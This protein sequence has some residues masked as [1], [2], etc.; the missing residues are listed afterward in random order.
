M[1]T[2]VIRDLTNTRWQLNEV[3]SG[4]TNLP[5]EYP[6]F[7]GH[8]CELNANIDGIK[9][10]G[11]A[12]AKNIDKRF[13]SDAGGILASAKTDSGILMLTL[14]NNLARFEDMDLFKSNCEAVG[15]HNLS[16]GVFERSVYL[17]ISLTTSNGNTETYTP[18]WASNITRRILTIYSGGDYVTNSEL[19]SWLQAN[20][21][22]IEYVEPTVP[23]LFMLSDTLLIGEPYKPAG[24]APRISFNEGTNK[25]KFE[26]Q[27]N[28]PLN[29]IEARITYGDTEQDIHVGELGDILTGSIAADTPYSLIIPVNDTIFKFG[30][31][32]YWLS[33]YARSSVDLTW[34]E[35]HF[36]LTR[37]GVNQ[38]FDTKYGNAVEVIV[39]DEV[40]K[41][42]PDPVQTG[43]NLDLFGGFEQQYT[44]PELFI[45]LG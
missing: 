35:T 37:D 15:L 28:L 23:S 3:L 31:G 29:Y 10:S 8:Y 19:I 6:I 34:S 4:T 44:E 9:I 13:I 42:F 17:G 25:I 14:D 27:S 5:S 39:R 38:G 43:T 18:H 20:A 16:L 12:Y 22:F 41:A 40:P 26:F 45:D 30:P 11:L 33:I 32:S 7:D 21:T 24:H 36:L 1:G 2:E